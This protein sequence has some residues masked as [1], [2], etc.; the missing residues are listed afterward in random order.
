MAL[1][2][3]ISFFSRGLKN[4][5]KVFNWA[6]LGSFFP[7]RLKTN[8]WSIFLESKGL[9]LTRYFFCLANREPTLSLIDFKKGEN[10]FTNFSLS[11]IKGE[12]DYLKRKTFKREEP[13]NRTARQIVMMKIIFSAPRLV[14]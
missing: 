6:R 14:R 8:F 10:F 9:L 2:S 5:G 3:L 11:L 12:I 4:L 13:I 1:K 7:E